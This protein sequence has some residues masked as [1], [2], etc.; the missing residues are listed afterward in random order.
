MSLERLRD[1]N[2]PFI[3][4]SEGWYRV[5]PRFPIDEPGAGCPM[6]CIYCNQ[7]FF[8]RS[9][10]GKRYG[11]W[12]YPG[13]E[14]GLSINT[15]LSTRR[16]P[17]LVKEPE[18]ILDALERYTFYTPNTSILF[19]NFND[20]GLDPAR[21]LKVAEGLVENGHQGLL[22]FYTKIGL[23]RKWIREIS[24]LQQAGGKP[25]IVISY[26][27]LPDV[28]E[29]GGTKGRFR[30]AKLSYKYDIPILWSLRPVIK[31][32]NDKERT[33]SRI[34]GEKGPLSSSIAVG[35]LYVHPDIIRAFREVGY[36]LDESYKN[37][38]FRI[39]KVAEEGIFQAIQ[40]VARQ[41]QLTAPIYKHTACAL[42]YIGTAFY[43]QP[44]PN[45]K[46]HWMDE[47]PMCEQVCPD[48]QRNVCK[49]MRDQDIGIVRDKVE[50]SLERLGYDP[51]N[52]SI[53][54]SKINPY[55]IRIV[56]GG[57]TWEELCFVSEQCGWR[58][59]NLPSIEI[60]EYRIQQV[61]KE[62]QIP[63]DVIKGL[64]LIGED[65]FVFLD[66]DLDG[67]NNQRLVNWFRSNAQA[68]VQAVNVN[69]ISNP[70]EFVENID[71]NI[72]GLLSLKEREE[73][74][75]KITD[76]VS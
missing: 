28:V 31:G 18:K 36:E 11:P 2:D 49:G 4:P 43:R 63:S 75:K 61:L 70:Q 72:L 39:V 53:I 17:V 35:G 15:R 76:I 19:E 46:A 48:I 6:G 23:G 27:G 5:N 60:L 12:L 45:R 69:L 55:K 3:S 29:P 74:I 52:Y 26:A 38:D 64:V 7:D 59:D 58:V 22:A 30:T 71:P 10:E 68:R 41:Q 67:H 54:R 20:T 24:R 51:S 62:R 40:G 73:I 56:G 21:T 13:V 25:V 16:G 34:L 8:N 44:T 50:K 65:W 66:G 9:P 37:H 33:L 1:K 14:P 57:L 47:W 42:A 32:I